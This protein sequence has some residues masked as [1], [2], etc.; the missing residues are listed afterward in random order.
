[1]LAKM[2][3]DP[4]ERMNYIP[5]DYSI[6]ILQKSMDFLDDL[7][8]LY[9]NKLHLEGICGDFFQLVRYASRVKDLS[10]SPKVFALL[11]NIFGNVDEEAIM[12]AVSRTMMQNDLFLLEVD[13][14]NSRKDEDLTVGYGSDE[15][16]RA[17]LLNPIVNYFKAQNKA[18]QAVITNYRFENNVYGMGRVPESKTVITF[19]H[20]GQKE[21]ERI[22]LIHSHK[23]ELQPLLEYLLKRWKLQH[24]K[25][26]QQ[27]NVCLLLFIKRR[28]SSK[29]PVEPPI[30]AAVTAMQADPNL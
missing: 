19:A 25:T 29:A 2:R 1:M 27:D 13:L 18:T 7:M 5:V 22:E 9:P 10:T 16:T 17:F 14:I 8:Q 11:G 4:E 20:Y 28:V 30:P 6:G 24:V 15:T 26:Y 21:Y 12:D 3:N 23:Y